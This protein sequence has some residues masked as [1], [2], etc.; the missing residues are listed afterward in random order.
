MPN[1]NPENPKTTTEEETTPQEK[2]VQ[3]TLDKESD[4]LM[5]ELTT[6]EGS[7]LRE[8]Y[9]VEKKANAG[10]VIDKKRIK[11]P[12]EYLDQISKV[13][14]QLKQE[15]QT[16]LRGELEKILS[17]HPDWNMKMEIP[18]GEIIDP[19]QQAAKNEFRSRLE[20]LRQVFIN[21]ASHHRLSPAFGKK[22]DRGDNEERIK[23]MQSF[24]ANNLGLDLETNPFVQDKLRME[25]YLALVDKGRQKGAQII[26][27]NLD[28]N[29]DVY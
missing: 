28:G 6:V 7:N 2:F 20:I 1:F 13:K 25:E 12:T 24:V 3:E 23:N 14:N 22:P 21:L 19:E 26:R 18:E 5:Q 4:F 16:L 17:Q 15:F 10:F 27:A 29:K 9:E 8:D 11:K